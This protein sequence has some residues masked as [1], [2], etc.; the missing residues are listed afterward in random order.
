MKERAAVF[1]LDKTTDFKDFKKKYLK[2]VKK[3]EN[4]GTMKLGNAEVR[5][6]Y[7]NEVSK[8]LDSI[9]KSLPIEDQARQAFEAR[10]RIRAEAMNMMAEE[11]T[12]KKL[13]IERPNKTFEELIES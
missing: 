12:R 9:D 1:G 6:W 5:Q 3:S 13:D 7:T 2:A 10:N 4:R 8:I 11:A